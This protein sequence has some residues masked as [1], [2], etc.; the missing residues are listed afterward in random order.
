[1]FKRRVRY[2]R[3][4]LEEGIEPSRVTWM[5]TEMS[6]RLLGILTTSVA[7]AFVG[8]AFCDSTTPLAAGHS[9]N[10]N[11]TPDKCDSAAIACSGSPTSIV[12][13]LV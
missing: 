8:K 13:Q 7:P 9:R 6:L 12:M 4:I 3:S 5:Q 1:L 2:R 10:R 11:A